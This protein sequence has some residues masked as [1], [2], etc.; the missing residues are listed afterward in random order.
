MSEDFKYIC[1]KCGGTIVITDWWDW[2]GGECSCG[3]EW[4][5]DE[6]M[7]G[8]SKWPVTRINGELTILLKREK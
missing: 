7:N 5:W 2:V 8:D 4:F 6:D 3:Q 1:P